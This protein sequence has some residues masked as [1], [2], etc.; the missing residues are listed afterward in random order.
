[1]NGYVN[2]ILWK[3]YKMRRVERE[4][5]K[6]VKMREDL[7]KG[8]EF[9]K[10]L[11]KEMT[12]GDTDYQASPRFWVLK[13]YKKERCKPED[14]ES[15]LFDMGNSE[16]MSMDEIINE[17]REEEDFLQEEAWETL[18]S[19]QKNSESFLAWLQDHV[20]INSERVCFKETSYIVPDT[21]FLSKKEAQE[22]LN[23][24]GYNYSKEAHTYA[25]TAHRAPQVEKLFKLLE[26]YPFEELLINLRAE[27]EEEV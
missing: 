5:E 1:M 27:N 23:L 17:L 8:L 21:F 25:M 6:D 12:E 22:H 4:L 11:Q 20:Y 16:L 7:V 19:A 14:A 10:E 13:D 15:F 9:L 26:T 24:Y 18:E 3:T 2:D